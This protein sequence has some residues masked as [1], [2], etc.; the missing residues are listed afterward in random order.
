[1]LKKS[2][3][4]QFCFVLSLVCSDIAI[5]GPFSHCESE[6]ETDE[7]TSFFSTVA[8]LDNEGSS[9]LFKLPVE[10]IL[11]AVPDYAPSTY[12]INGERKHMPI[13]VRVIGSDT[14][15]GL[16][17]YDQEL[18][19]IVRAGAD[20]QDVPGT[21]LFRVNVHDDSMWSFVRW[22]APEDQVFTREF[23]DGWVAY[24]CADSRSRDDLN[25]CRFYR[26]YQEFFYSFKLTD[27]NIEYIDEVEKLV[28]RRI[29]SW[30]CTSS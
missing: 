4:L 13:T 15:R 12:P 3:T 14:V 24:S 26:V 20:Y 2:L 6:H 28:N 23:L 9:R 1:M 10:E 19:R 25:D 30:N 21:D 18:I 22:K 29:E 5:A 11:A 27:N 7:L 17:Q 8:G 16:S